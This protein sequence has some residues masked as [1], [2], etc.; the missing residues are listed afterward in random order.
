[1]AIQRPARESAPSSPW[2]RRPR[3]RARLETRSLGS[4]PTARVAL[5]RRAPPMAQRRSGT[6]CRPRPSRRGRT[7]RA[8]RQRPRHAEGRRASSWAERRAAQDAARDRKAPAKAQRSHCSNPNPTRSRSPRWHH[9]RATSDLRV[10]AVDAQA[11]ATRRAQG[12]APPARGQ[13]LTRSY[14]HKHGKTSR[15]RSV[16]QIRRG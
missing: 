8:W 2:G 3:R 7:E 13:L 1:M 15:Q 16:R 10:A 12:R 11:P 6:A 4:R 9:G 5:R 14:D